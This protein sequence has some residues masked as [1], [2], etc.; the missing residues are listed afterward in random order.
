MSSITRRQFTATSLASA[1]ASVA[2]PDTPDPHR[3]TFVVAPNCYPG[4]DF[5]QFLAFVRQTPLCNVELPV[6]A[7]GPNNLI[8]DWLVDAPL[9]GQWRNSLPD[10]KQLLA[11]NGIRIA[12]LGAAG[13]IGHPGSERLL[14]N[15]IDLAVRLGVPL[16]NIACGPGANPDVACPLLRGT[17]LYARQQGVRLALETWGGLTRNAEECL[18]TLRATESAD[19]GINVDTGNVLLGNPDMPADALPDEIRRIGKRLAYVHLK[20]VR[21]K[22]GEAPVT[23]ILGQGEID[24]KKIF[25]ACRELGFYGPFGLDLE[26]TQARQAHDPQAHHHALLDSLDHLCAIGEFAPQTGFLKRPTPGSK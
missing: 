24:F 7:D 21:R 9:G 4:T 6:G 20:D 2:L 25:A 13:Y 17:G 10:L 1:A 3:N 22:P 14:R 8:P 23:T 26:T 18:R 12:C 19:I 11:Q 16:F 5:A 15:R